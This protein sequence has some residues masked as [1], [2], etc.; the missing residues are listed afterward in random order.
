V[1]ADSGVALHEVSASA[2]AAALR[3]LIADPTLRARYGEEARQRCEALF[4]IRAA[5]RRL[6]SIYEEILQERQRSRRGTQQ[7]SRALPG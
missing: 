4:D 2:I 1:V 6:D 7:A 5:A 3:R